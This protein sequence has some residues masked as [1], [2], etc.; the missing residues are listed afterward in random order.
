MAALG[1]IVLLVLVA[2]FAGPIT[3]LTGRAG[4]AQ[5]T[6]YLDEFKVG[7]RADADNWFGT[8]SLGRSV[9]SRVLAGAAVS[10]RVLSSTGII[11]VIGV[12]IGMVAATSA[13]GPAPPCRGRWTSSWASFGPAARLGLGNACSFGD[14]SSR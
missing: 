13:A 11:L 1:F 10:L 6:E 8:D 4:P 9:F 5:S 3:K 12:T 2:I 14:G 7:Q